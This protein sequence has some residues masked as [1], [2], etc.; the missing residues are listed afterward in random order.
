MLSHSILLY[1]NLQ[2]LL[3]VMLGCFQCNS[4]D[5]GFVANLKGIYDALEYISSLPPLSHPPSLSLLHFILSI[6]SFFASTLI[7]H[8]PWPQAILLKPVFDSLC[9]DAS[10]L[11]AKVRLSL[12]AILHSLLI[13]TFFK[14]PILKHNWL[15]SLIQEVPRIVHKEIS[16]RGQDHRRNQI[17]VEIKTPKK[18]VSHQEE[19][20]V[21]L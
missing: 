10:Y 9:Q 18:G 20:R 19:L 1:K 14:D 12:F 16:P 15:P 3:A 5:P 8:S 7:G 13:G 6:P 2:T 17:K 11:G 21:S 4:E